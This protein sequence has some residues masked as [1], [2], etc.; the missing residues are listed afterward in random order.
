MFELYDM[1]LSLSIGQIQIRTNK[2]VTTSNWETA[3]GEEG[4]KRQADKRICFEVGGSER[5]KSTEEAR[6]MESFE[7][8]KADWSRYKVLCY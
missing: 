1:K 8:F 2:S 5:T 7:S 6:L 3:Q 4:H